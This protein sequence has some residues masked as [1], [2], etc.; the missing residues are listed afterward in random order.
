MNKKGQFFI[1]S[2]VV[3]AIALTTIIGLLTIPLQ[4]TTTSLT[5][6]TRDLNDMRT[7]VNNLKTLTNSLYNYWPAEQTMMTEFTAK[8]Y[9][10]YDALNNNFIIRLGIDDY[11]VDNSFALYSNGR[12]ILATFSQNSNGTLIISFKDTILKGEEKEYRVFYSV[13]TDSQRALTNSAENSNYEDNATHVKYESPNYLVLMNKTTGLITDLKIKGYSNDLI[14]Y[15]GARVT[16]AT[17]YTQDG[18]AAEVAVLKYSNNVLLVNSSGRINNTYV[19]QLY[20]FHPGIISVNQ[21]YEILTFGLYN[22]SYVINATTELDSLAYQ[23]TI[24]AG[25]I[26]PAEA[27]FGSDKY[28]TVFRNNNTGFGILYSQ[29]STT[30]VITGTGTDTRV[31]LTNNDYSTTGIVRQE[32]IIV[33]YYNGYNYSIT[34]G[35]NFANNPAVAYNYTKN[36]YLKT[37][38]QQFDNFLKSSLNSFDFVTSQNN[39]LN[40]Q[41]IIGKNNNPSSIPF[42]CNTLSFYNKDLNTLEITNNNGLTAPY[43]ITTQ[44]YHNI[45][46]L[47]FNTVNNAGEG[48]AS[49]NYS[50]MNPYG[51]DFTI[52]VSFNSETVDDAIAA[53][54]YAPNN[55]I[56]NITT[57]IPANPENWETREVLVSGFNV[58]GVYTLNLAGDNSVFTASTTLPL[59]SAKAPLIINA[60]LTQQIY[61]ELGKTETLTTTDINSN[62][63]RITI[64]NTDRT[65][66][67]NT[68]SFT[69]A[70]NHTYYTNTPYYLLMTPGV[71]KISADLN[72]GLKNY[73]LSPENDVTYVISDRVLGKNYYYLNSSDSTTIKTVQ[74]SNMSYSDSLKELNNSLYSWDFDDEEFT[75]AGSDNWFHGGD[76]YA[77][78]G[79]YA[80][81]TTETTSFTYNSLIENTTLFKSAL[82]TSNVITPIITM[83]N[84]TDLFKLKLVNNA[85]DDYTFGLEMRVNGNNDEYYKTSFNKEGALT[86]TE[87]FHYSNLTSSEWNYIAKNDSNN[88]LGLFFQSNDLKQANNV[89]IINDDYLR[90][91]LNKYGDKILYFYLGNDWNDLDKILSE[92]NNKPLCYDELIN[93]YFNYNS[94]NAEGSGYIIG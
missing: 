6:Q 53:T 19:T 92:L 46:Y 2:T 94:E 39:T 43:G 80:A 32:I 45:S 52:T 48:I 18:M 16:N 74:Y 38:W 85:D 75:L 93:C 84:N 90:I 56:V 25:I 34:A 71:M 67:N 28:Y 51:N 69:N 50:L 40:P 65:I 89:L 81:C 79:T 70:I 12:I 33:P 68:G 37:V 73:Y 55:T 5:S 30:S 4:L 27:S 11:A 60:T 1:I 29:E 31:Q 36:E 35:K 24:I 13:M 21:E 20:S 58:S 3:M 83:N 64:N 66:I 15:M 77:C 49:T 47:G 57:I 91:G 72:L 61:F 7:A 78:T 86:G 82:F 23:D 10:D 62:A 54:V 8:D 42:E 44:N 22:L 87:F 63:P 76:F 14:T 9:N 17:D 88:V 59:I 26:Q 41:I